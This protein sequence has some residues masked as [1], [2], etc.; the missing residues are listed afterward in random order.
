MNFSE[1]EHST[2][3]ARDYQHPYHTQQAPGGRARTQRLYDE[4]G[5]RHSSREQYDERRRI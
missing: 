5:D 2:E 4:V 3:K 1:A